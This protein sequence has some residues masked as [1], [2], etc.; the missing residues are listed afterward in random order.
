MIAKAAYTGALAVVF[1]TAFVLSTTAQPRNPIPVNP[2]L[3][4]AQIGKGF[5][6][7]VHQ[8]VILTDRLPGKDLPTPLLPGK[9]VTSVESGKQPPGG[10][11]VIKEPS[12]SLRVSKSG[13]QDVA[14]ASIDIKGPGGKTITLSTGNSQGSC[15]L[16]ST[17][18]RCSDGKG[19]M[20]SASNGGCRRSA[21]SG[22]CSMK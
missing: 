14:E 9:N 19:N 4:A 7:A 22:S 1:A 21:G 12:T 6:T 8:G 10:R 15:S 16:T 18:A 17:G 5:P 20:A 2:S 11:A 3:P 13:G